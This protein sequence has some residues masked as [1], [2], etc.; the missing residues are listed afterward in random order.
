MDDLALD[1]HKNDL[2][3]QSSLNKNDLATIEFIKS[4]LVRV[5]ILIET[6]VSIHI[7]LAPTIIKSP[8]DNHNFNNRLKCS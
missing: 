4:I 3:L 8:N 6:Y 2:V 5:S 7:R 1:S